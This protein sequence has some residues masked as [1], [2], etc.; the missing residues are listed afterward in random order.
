MTLR[1]SYVALSVDDATH[2]ALVETARTR[3]MSIAAVVREAI[4]AHIEPVPVRISA[5]PAPPATEARASARARPRGGLC[6]PPVVPGG[7][8]T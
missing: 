8:R 2:A 6:M 3:G 4:A 1:C 5:S 7:R